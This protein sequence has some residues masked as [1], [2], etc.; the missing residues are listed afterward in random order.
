MIILSVLIVTVHV[1]NAKLLKRRIVKNVHLGLKRMSM[2]IVY[3]MMDM[4]P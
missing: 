4:N 1:V 2:D 3:A